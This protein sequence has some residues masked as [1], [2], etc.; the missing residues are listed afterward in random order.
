MRFGR[1]RRCRRRSRQDHPP[2][3]L[4]DRCAAHLFGGRFAAHI[5]G[6]IAAEHDAIRSRYP[7]QRFELPGAIGERI[8][9]D[10]RREEIGELVPDDS[11]ILATEA[12]V[13]KVIE[14]VRPMVA[15]RTSMTASLRRA[16]GTSN[17]PR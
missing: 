14:R 5:E 11:E 16:L 3:R 2:F 12:A 1:D 8:E 6:V 7:H 17:S 4:G 10:P 15:A 13:P 9:A